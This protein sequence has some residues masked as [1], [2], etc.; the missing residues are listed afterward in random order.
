MCSVLYANDCF[1]RF[2]DNS[3]ALKPAKCRVICDVISSK[4]A[5]QTHYTAESFDGRMV[6][7][8]AKH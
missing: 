2:P 1:D 7:R 5:S 6:S 8:N 4:Q 3:A